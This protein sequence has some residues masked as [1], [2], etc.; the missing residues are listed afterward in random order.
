[1]D[2]RPKGGKEVNK[3]R[4]RINQRF[5]IIAGQDTVIN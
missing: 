3:N 4:N 1:M 5:A 2:Y